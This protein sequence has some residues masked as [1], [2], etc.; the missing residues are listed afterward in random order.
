MY[1]ACHTVCKHGGAHHATGTGGDAQQ[2]LCEARLGC[3]DGSPQLGAP[4]PGQNV[5]ADTACK[6]PANNADSVGA[7]CEGRGALESHC[8]FATGRCA[9]LP[10]VTCYRQSIKSP[11]PPPPPSLSLSLS[12]AGGYTTCKTCKM[13]VKWLGVAKEESPAHIDRWNS[14]RKGGSQD[15]LKYDITTTLLP[16]FQGEE[17]RF[18]HFG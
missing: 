9:Y 10:S 1:Q 13:L 14:P 18:G 16:P 3:R 2:G 4:G 11:P 5:H 6:H 12:T 17:V 7:A 15:R 8:D